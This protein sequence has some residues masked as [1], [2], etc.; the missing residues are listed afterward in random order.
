MPNARNK[1]MME[2]IK[3]DLADAKAVSVIDACART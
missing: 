3:A 1:E 2:N